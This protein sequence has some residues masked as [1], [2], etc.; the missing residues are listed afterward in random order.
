MA[1]K[2]R[3]LG[4][5]AAALSL[6][7]WYRRDTARAVAR[8]GRFD[9]RVVRTPWGRVEY[10]ESGRGEA[11]LLIHGVVGGWDGAST[12]RTFVPPG[13]RT[14]IPARF[15]YLGSTMPESATPAMQA[16]A[17]IAVLDALEVEEAPVLG[18]S[19]GSTSAVQLALRHPD[20]ISRLLLL[21][22]NAPHPEPLTLPPRALAPYLFSQPVF[23]I[24]RT[25]ARPALRRLAGFPAGFARDPRSRREEAEILDSFFPVSLR[26]E[27]IVFDSYDSNPDIARY[28]LEEITVPTLVIHARDDPIASYDDAREMAGRI[29]GARFVTVPRGGHVFMHH[30][31]AALAVVW[32]FLSR[33]SDDEP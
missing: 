2:T 4:A 9:V 28:A 17:F 25:F 31:D 26:T 21:C 5:L 19:A 12:W 29:R 13:Y 8:L 18:F 23:W 27:G 7:L 20:R 11:V 1:S 24:A 3:A 15:G 33:D 30:D 10:C 32:E 6:G 14:I 16:D 22:A